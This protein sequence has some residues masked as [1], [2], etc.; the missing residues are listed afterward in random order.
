LWDEAQIEISELKIN[1]GVEA[2]IIPIVHESSKVVDGHTILKY[3]N[4]K[5]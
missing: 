4:R 3:I 1:K 2:P 5:K